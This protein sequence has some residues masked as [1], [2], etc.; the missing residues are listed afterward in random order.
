MSSV[1]DVGE[2]ANP[3]AP[4]S[5]ETQATPLQTLSTATISDGGYLA[6]AEPALCD[7]DENAYFLIVP[8]WRDGQDEPTAASGSPSPRDV[9]RVS[10]D[11]KKR[12]TFSPGKGSKFANATELRT[13]AVA[14]DQNGALFMLIWA[15]WRDNVGQ[16]EKSGQY[17]VSFDR[18]GEYRSHLEVDWQEILVNQF[19]VFGSGEFLLRG[20]RI[21]PAESRLA[22]LSASG[23]T[24][25]DVGSSS[26]QP[27]DEPSPES[28]PQSKFDRMVRGG[29]GRIYVT[30][31]EDVGQGDVV[32]A[33]S[34]SGQ[35]E[36]VFKLPPMP[37][38]PP[39]VAWKAADD[40]FAA[41]YRSDASSGEQTSRWWIAVYSNVA[42][43]PEP[44]TTLYG[45]APGPLICYQHKRSG[46]RFTFLTEGTRL[47]TMSAR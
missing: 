25:Q 46:D 5:A 29:D 43:G 15:R 2:A 37:K 23:Q 22:I 6:W 20:R 34:A 24:L 33:I 40:R 36:R 7:E 31:E 27:L 47:V 26:G 12:I 13:M 8:H 19:E 9:L 39:L 4:V 42:D 16:P 10:S 21:H 1:V 38:D 18:K 44:E 30:R 32:Y 35:S 41:S 28:T 3:E 17:I 45:P 14:V 11:G